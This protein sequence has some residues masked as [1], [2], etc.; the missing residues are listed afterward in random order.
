VKPPLKR[1]SQSVK[2]EAA[3]QMNLSAD[4]ERLVEK[5]E[6]ILQ[7]SKEEGTVNTDQQVLHFCILH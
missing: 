2:P 5:T 6:T 4:E 7:N 3:D 1:A